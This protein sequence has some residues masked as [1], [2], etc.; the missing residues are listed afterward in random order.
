MWSASVNFFSMGL[1]RLHRD[2]AID[3]GT[4]NTV[5][6]CDGQKVL[7]EPSIVAM[8]V[9]SG[10]VIAIG[11]EAKVMDGKVNPGIETVCPLSDGVI[12]DFNAAE[13]MIKGF[14]KKAGVGTNLLFHPYLRIVVGIPCGSTQVEK[15]A[16]RDSVEHAGGRDV[17]LIY[18][19]MASALGVGLDINKANGNMVVDIGGGTTEIA[20]LS[21]G[22]MVVK[23]SVRLAGNEL[24]KDIQDYLRMQHNVL[25]GDNEA[26][27][28]KFSIGSVLDTLPEDEAP[29]PVQV[30]GRNAVTGLPIEVTVS[31]DEIAACT[32]GTISKIEAE[33]L[34]V[35]Q[36]T[37]PSVY[38]DIVR[39][40]I[41]LAGGGALLRGI[42][43]RFSEKVNIPFHVAEDPLRAVA[44]GT[45]DALGHLEDYKFLMR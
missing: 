3:L 5:I 18:E 27:Q 36:S 32:N 26:E 24:T 38:T 12:G 7:D 20:V 25:V 11:S 15:R 14:V 8:D 39:N 13:E 16:V 4:A 29:D 10:K 23:S 45:C 41:W 33:I 30:I 6:F 2:L 17:Y 42:A 34:R 22:G 21:L 28:I 31:Y 43:R 35:L 19:P 9:K 1:F 37:P 40:G 44:R